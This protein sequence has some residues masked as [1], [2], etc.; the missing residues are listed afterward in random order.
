MNRKKITK[1]ELEQFLRKHKLWLDDDPEGERANLSEADLREADLSGANLSEADLREADLSGA[2]L[3]GA[4]LSGANLS[5]ANL[6]FSCLPLW[7]GSLGAHFDDRQ[8][9][10]IAYHLVKAGLKSKNASDETKTELA[11]LI[12]LANN[13]HRVNECG[14][15]QKEKEN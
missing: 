5:G 2:N 6:D 8:L 15:I 14:K 13:F 7:C 3:I 9:T 10:Q 1:E 4:D 11:K 12:D